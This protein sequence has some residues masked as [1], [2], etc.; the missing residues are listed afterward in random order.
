MYGKDVCRGGEGYGNTGGLGRDVRVVAVTMREGCE[1]DEERGVCEARE[2]LQLL[3]GGKGG[4]VRLLERE[5]LEEGVEP[6]AGGGGLSGV[7][8]AGQRESVLAL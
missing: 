3:R 1:L 8:D 2:V 6:G 7:V 5:V 4:K